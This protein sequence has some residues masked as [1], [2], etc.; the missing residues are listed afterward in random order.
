MIF[1][2]DLQ[3]YP[4]K[5]TVT[6][7]LHTWKCNPNKSS[8]A[9]QHTRFVPKPKRSRM[10]QAIA[11]IL[12]SLLRMSQMNINWTETDALATLFCLATR[13]SFDT[14]TPR[15]FMYFKT[16]LTLLF[17]LPIDKFYIESKRN[18]MLSCHQ[19][20]KFPINSGSLDKNSHQSPSGHDVYS[21]IA[22]CY[23]VGVQNARFFE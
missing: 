2:W 8:V 13:Q 12:S 22:R 9:F 14:S 1:W 20:T 5:R 11:S 21:G 15:S 3:Q 23:F 17:F 4:E 18:E 6:Q 19:A 10:F 7:L 16:A